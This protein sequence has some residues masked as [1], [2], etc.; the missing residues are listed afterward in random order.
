MEDFLEESE[1]K[2]HNLTVIDD[3]ICGSYVSYVVLLE[4]YFSLLAEFLQ[5]VQREDVHKQLCLSCL[6]R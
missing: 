5:L 6:N 4:Y 3:D 2:P 1:K